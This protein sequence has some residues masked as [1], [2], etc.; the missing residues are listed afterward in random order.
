MISKVWIGSWY[1]KFCFK[2]F[3]ASKFAWWFFQTTILIY[4]MKIAYFLFQRDKAG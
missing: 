1:K 4:K 3:E 2:V